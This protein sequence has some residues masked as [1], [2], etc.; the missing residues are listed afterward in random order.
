MRV[1]IVGAG[2]SGLTLA[3]LLEGVCETTVLEA[4]ERAGGAMR[5]VHVSVADR[6]ATVDL[7]AQDISGDLFPLHRALLRATGLDRHVV[8]SPASLTV[9]R[10]GEAVPLL[11]SPH[12]PESRLPRRT[13]LGPAWDGIGLFLDRARAM[14]AADESWETPLADLV[15]P[16]PVSEAIKRDVLYARSAFLFCCGVEQARE[17]SAR[18]AIAFYANKDG[19]P[20]WQHLATGLESLAWALAAQSPSATIRTGAGVREV[21]RSGAG[22]EVLDTAGERRWFDELVLAVPPW[23]ALPILGPLAGTGELRD[24]LRAFEYVNA[25]YALHLDPAYLPPDRRHWST[26]TFEV[27]D[28][29]SESTDWFGPS[30]GVDVFKSQITHRRPPPG[31]VIAQARYRHLLITPAAVRARRHLARLSGHGGLHFA[32]HHTNWVSSQESAVRSA[33]EAARRIAPRSARLSGL[34]A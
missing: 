26:S 7:G 13:V 4:G 17:L 10:A 5:S 24:T 21:R 9:R 27:H 33:V 20:G 18:A 19:E 31:Q 22:F 14:D 16:L 8:G 32:G 30:H 23:A 15:E 29:W 2:L 3:W 6:D 12:T 34:T 25:T 11:V 28:G 1:G